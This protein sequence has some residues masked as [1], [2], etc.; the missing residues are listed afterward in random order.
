MIKKIKYK[1]AKRKFVRKR[2]YSFT[3]RNNGSSIQNSLHQ[4]VTRNPSGNLNQLIFK[5]KMGYDV[6]G[7]I[8]SFWYA[9]KF[10]KQFNLSFEIEKKRY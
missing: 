1:L 7:F 8:G 9:Y 10:S 2:V 6:R 4:I 3:V 5:L